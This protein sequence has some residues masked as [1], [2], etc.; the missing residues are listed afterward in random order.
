[1]VKKLMVVMAMVMAI[2][3]TTLYA[4]GNSTFEKDCGCTYENLEQVMHGLLLQVD[5]R[6]PEPE[7]GVWMKDLFTDEELDMIF[8]EAN[9]I[10]RKRAISAWHRM[11]VYNKKMF[12]AAMKDFRKDVDEIK[13]LNSNKK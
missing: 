2:Y 8:D 5:T 10:E 4:E 11:S 13:G 7:G 12:D 6:M 1:M 9:P 3:S